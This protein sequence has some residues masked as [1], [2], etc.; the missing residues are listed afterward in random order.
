MTSWLASARMLSGAGFM[1]ALAA[2]PPASAADEATLL[3]EIG[4]GIVPVNGEILLRVDGV[5]GEVI[6]QPGAE[7]EIQFQSTSMEQ[8]KEEDEVPVAIWS[9][10]GAFRIAPP[11]GQ[12]AVRTRLRVSIPARMRARLDLENATVSVGSL[13]GEL[14]VH[15]RKIHVD[16]VGLLKPADF[17]I[18]LG[19]V[20]VQGAAKGVKILGRDLEV[21]LD[22]I[23]GWTDLRLSGGTAKLTGLLSGLKGHF[24]ATRVAIDTISGTVNL[25]FIDGSAEIARLRDGGEVALSGC[26]LRM[27]EL[28]GTISVESDSDVRF[29]DCKASVR[30]ENSGGAVKGLRNEGMIDVTTQG[31][32]V[33]F[34][35][36]VGRLR[37]AGDGLDVQLENI[38]AELSVTTRSSRVLLDRASATVTIASIDGDVTIKRASGQVVVKTQRGD[39]SLSDMEGPLSVE[40]EG[41]HVEVAWTA[42]GGESDS[43]IRNEGGDVTVRLPAASD[44]R[45]EA[46]STYGRVESNLPTVRILQEG[47]SA[48]GV[49]G[50]GGQRTVFIQA[51][52]DVHILGADVLNPSG[53]AP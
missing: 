21:V 6:L 52:E 16:A 28:S 44:C 34:A 18:E 49:V 45:I 2:H 51:S 10:D 12:A 30:V 53:Q 13:G 41:P 36:T 14:A 8:G 7:S 3:D 35:H 1:L 40:A 42:I 11:R 24:T 37:V 48:Q 31:A 25:R 32:P 27:E 23:S 50:R 39:V 9:D 19:A 5:E 46:T 15:G 43:H 22:G 20:R 38:G 4:S 33:T 17:E 29:D 26:P 47:G